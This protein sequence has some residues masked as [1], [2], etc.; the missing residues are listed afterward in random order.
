MLA[1][2]VVAAV[3]SST[4]LVSV[5]SVKSSLQLN[6]ARHGRRQHISA[7]PS[8]TAIQRHGYNKHQSSPSNYDDHAGSKRL[9]SA[10]RLQSNVTGETVVAVET[11]AV[12]C[13]VASDRLLLRRRR[14]HRQ[15]QCRRR[16]HLSPGAHAHCHQLL[17]GKPRRRWHPRLCC[18]TADHTARERLH[19]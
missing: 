14:R 2:A 18:S 11:T 9:Y 5:K 7:G 10:D 16:G 4:L 8:V 1:Y 3:S 6:H 19:W 13:P 12:C 15:Q 17:P